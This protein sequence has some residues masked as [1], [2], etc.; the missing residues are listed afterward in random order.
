MFDALRTSSPWARDH[1]AAAWNIGLPEANGESLLLGDEL[2][3]RAHDA[4]DRGGEA[5]PTRRRDR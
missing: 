1:P 5:A 3:D 2:A 4:D